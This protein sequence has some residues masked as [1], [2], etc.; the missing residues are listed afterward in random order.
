M[1]FGGAVGKRSC[2]GRREDESAEVVCMGG[3][4]C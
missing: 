2:S 3:E 4:M 1:R